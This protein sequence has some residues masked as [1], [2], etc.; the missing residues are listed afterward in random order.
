M[1]TRIVQLTFQEHLVADFLKI[2]DES[3]PRIR[4]SEGCSGLDRVRDI[5]HP[6]VFF[7]ISKW[8]NEAALESYRNSDLFKNTWAKTK[9]LFSVS[10][11][12][13]STTDTGK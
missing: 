12:A 4:A 13:W 9:P 10:A 11:H 8:D 2:F 1:I 6:N 5:Y 3:G 7:T